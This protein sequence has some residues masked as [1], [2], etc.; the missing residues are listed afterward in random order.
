M[1]SA[2]LKHNKPRFPKLGL[3]PKHLTNALFAAHTSSPK[4]KNIFLVKPEKR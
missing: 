3:Q 4:L 2:S 1:L